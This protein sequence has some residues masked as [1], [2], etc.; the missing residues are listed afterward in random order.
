MATYDLNTGKRIDE[1]ES[2][3]RFL[4]DNE[5][6]FDRSDPPKLLYDVIPEFEGKKVDPQDPHKPNSIEFEG[7]R[8]KL[9]IPTRSD[10]IEFE[11]TRGNMILMTFYIPREWDNEGKRFGHGLSE[12][13]K[14]L[15]EIGRELGT[16]VQNQTERPSGIPN[17]EQP[18]N[19]NKLL[20]DVD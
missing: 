15:A 3:P 5:F 11:K 9:K 14:T 2:K 20:K 8:V 19:L 6:E 17:D 12:G 1:P 16:I 4:V 7:E 18:H 10:Y 13:R